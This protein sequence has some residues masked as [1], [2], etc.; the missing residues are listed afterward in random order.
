MKNVLFSI[1]II[2]SGI[3]FADNSTIEGFIKTY[4]K[5]IENNSVDEWFTKNTHPHADKNLTLLQK[6]WQ[7][8]VDCHFNKGKKTKEI[9]KTSTWPK[10]ERWEIKKAEADNMDG[11]IVYT[12]KPEKDIIFYHPKD[13]YS[14]KSTVT[15]SKFKG[16][17]Y[18]V[19]VKKSDKNI[20]N[21][22][23]NKSQHYIYSMSPNC[24]D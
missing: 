3:S 19:S 23:K 11:E 1:L 21:I 12:V 18:L 8:I 17:W 2:Y 24:F 16:R 13:P 6:K 9:K 5:S 7:L 22:L 10:H 20:K 15:V 14:T 4:E